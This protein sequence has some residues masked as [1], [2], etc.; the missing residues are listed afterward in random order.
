MR[1]LLII[2]LFCISL[3]AG[4]TKYYV[5]NA[6]N[7]LNTGLSDAQAW[8]SI[9]KVNAAASGIFHAGD[10]ILFKRGDTWRIRLW[11]DDCGTSD[12]WLTYSAY[13]TGDKPKFFNSV[14]ANETSDWTEVSANIWQNSNVNF[15]IDVA[16]L[17]FNDEESCGTKLMTATPTFTTQGQ[18]WYDFVND[19]I[20]LYS[21]GNPATFYTNIECVLKNY[22]IMGLNVKYVIIENLDC[23]YAHFGII[24]QGYPDPANISHHVILRDCDFSYIGGGDFTDSYAI[25]LGDAISLND[26]VMYHRDMMQDLQTRHQHQGILNIIFISGITLLKNAI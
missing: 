9:Q 3:T 10:S 23:R 1:N 22:S 25:R 24:I 7:D 19:R 6:G 13:G 2:L 5:K 8:S 15:T 26:N 4:A 18:F 11:I 12:A 17:V 16:N 20:R 14:S 21:V